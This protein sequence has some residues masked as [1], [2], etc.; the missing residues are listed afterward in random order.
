MIP[1]VLVL[2]KASGPV[3]ALL[4][5]PKPRVYPFDEAPQ[6]PTYPYVT[7]QIIAGAPENFLS[8]L[9]DMDS[10]STQIDVWASDGDSCLA[11]AK[12]VRDALETSA[13]MTDFGNTERDP[14]TQAYRYRMTFDFFKAR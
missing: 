4:G 1:P 6:S 13:Y 14:D 2:L 11:V 7:W 12:A 10:Y 3:T 9:P 5:H 8:Q